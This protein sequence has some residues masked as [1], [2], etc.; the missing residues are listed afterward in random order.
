[1]LQQEVTQAQQQLDSITANLTQAQASGDHAEVTR[2]EAQQTAAA[3]NLGTVKA[4]VTSTT[5][6]TRTTTQQ[7]IHG[8]QVVSPATPGKRAVKKTLVL[9]GIGGL[10][11]GMVIGMVIVII[12]AVTSDRLR[13]RDDVAYAMAARWGSAWVRCAP[14][15][16]HRAWPRRPAARHGTCCRVPA[17][18][19]TRQVQGTSGLAVI[20]VDNAPTVAAGGRRAGDCGIEAAV[21]DRPG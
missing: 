17:Q 1:M 15:G 6:S 2:L 12:G 20:A 19:R 9:Y 5:V 18:C 16:C 21:A 8:S 7:M 11:G 13:R 3:N 14:V 4:N 10:L